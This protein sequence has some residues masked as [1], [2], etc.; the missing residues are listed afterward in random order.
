MKEYLKIGFILFGI[1]A[2]VA[3]LLSGVNAL[4]F[5]KIA[6]LEAQSVLDAQAEVL[7][8]KDLGSAQ[9][10]S[11]TASSTDTSVKE[12][13]QYTFADGKK[14]FC[15]TCAPKGYGGEIVMVVGIGENSEVSG[16]KIISH[17][18]TPGLGAK[19]TTDENFKS[20]FVGKAL[21]G[22]SIEI[23]AIS[24]ATISSTAVKKAVT[25]S[26]SATRRILE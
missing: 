12:Y 15:F 1:T 7:E 19:I 23:D 22:D 21:E 18:E 26:L 11:F 17:S 8:G 6:E 5:E 3:L 10:E 16:I 20:Q 24:G 9:I 13:T 14:A 2:V 4:T 25:D